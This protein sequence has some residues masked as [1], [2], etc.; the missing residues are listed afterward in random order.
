MGLAALAVRSI[1]ELE[2]RLLALEGG[3]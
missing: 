2:T 3:K 1:Q